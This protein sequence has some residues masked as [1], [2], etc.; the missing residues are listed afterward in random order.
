MF[1][2]DCKYVTPCGWCTRKNQPCEIKERE[3]RKMMQSIM[4]PLKES[5]GKDAGI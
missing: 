5:E 4:T 3:K 1:I 2:G